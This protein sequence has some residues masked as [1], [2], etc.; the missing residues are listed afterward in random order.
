MDYVV[1]ASR[2]IATETGLLPHANPGLMSERDLRALREWNVSVGLMLETSSDRLVGTRRAPRA[3]A[4]QAP[5]APASDDR[6]GRP[7]RHRVHDRHPLRD[8][9]DAGRARRHASGD[10]GAPRAPRA[11]PGGNRPELPGQ[12]QHPDGAASRAVAG[13]PAP[14]TGG[15]P[16]AA[17][18]AHERA[19]PA[20]PLAGNLSG[21][22]R[23]GAERLGRRLAPHHRPHQSRGALASPRRARGGDGRGRL[24]ACGSD[25]PS[26]PSS[27]I[28]PASSPD[29]CGTACSPW[30]TRPGSSPT[31]RRTRPSDGRGRQSNR[32]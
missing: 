30:W 3:G 15:R 24:P 32:R 10:P 25:W 1:A 17:R 26:I 19:G 29:P 11:R 31:G 28:V 14:D 18:R 13:R 2:A 4:G 8:R 23:L 21:A 22:D 20:Q 27:F 6:G 5:G 7:S 9:R 16:T 12:A